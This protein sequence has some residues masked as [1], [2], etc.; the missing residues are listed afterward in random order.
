VNINSSTTIAQNT[1]SSTNL[2][3]SSE[4]LDIYIQLSST[5]PLSTLQSIEST[6]HTLATSNTTRS[7]RTQPAKS[8]LRAFIHSLAADYGFASESFDPEPH[9]HVFILKP[10]TW[11]A[12]VFGLGN[13]VSA[14]GIAG[15]SV[16]ECVKLRD[17]HRFKEREAQRLAAAEVKAQRDAAKAQAGTEEGGG[18]GSGWAQVAASKRG[19]GVNNS[20]RGTPMSRTPT[21]LSGSGS[22]Y[23]ALA[24]VNDNGEAPAFRKEKLVLRSGVGAAKQARTPPAE[25]ADSWEEEEEKEEEEERRKSGESAEAEAEARPADNAEAD[26]DATGAADAAQPV[27]SGF[28]QVAESSQAADA[29]ETAPAEQEHVSHD[30]M[31]RS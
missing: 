16:A 21:A 25:V 19:T 11:T 9:R 29:A 14:I 4:T 5:S 27:D 30:T 7:V 8:S 31:I 28:A 20:P 13:G 24:A 1:L 22:L 3:Y 10:T 23:A 6:L 26:A 15:M 17:R 2:P 12:P 18:G